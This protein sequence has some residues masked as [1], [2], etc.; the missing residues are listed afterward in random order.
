[1]TLK[2]CMVF[3]L[4]FLSA[5]SDN[6]GNSNKNKLAETER[7]NEW[8]DLRYEEELLQS[9]MTMTTLGQKKQYH[10]IDDFSEQTE[11]LLL[12][13]RAN[14]V[15]ELQNNFDYNNLSDDA[16]TSYDLWVY[17]YEQAASMAVYRRHQYVF[18]HMMGI[19][20]YLPNFMINFH[21]VDTA[22]DMN[23]YIS[24]IGGISRAIDQL[25]YR[26]QI[27]AK[28][29]VRP[30]KFSY[31]GV[32]DQSK[33]LIL[34]R[35]FDTKSSN[36]SPLLAD[37][38][39]KIKALLKAGKID[40]EQ[41]IILQSNTEKALLE[42]FYPAYTALIQWFVEDANNAD[43][44]ARGVSVLPQGDDFY[45]AS[46]QK[47]TTTMMTA[48]EIH[49][50]GLAEVKRLRSEMESIK[51]KVKFTGTLQQ[52]FAFIKA[53]PEF[54]Y[55]NTDVGRQEYIDDA[56][57]YLEKINNQLP[58][59]FGLLP[60][61]KLVVKRV[62]AFR[63]QDGAPQHYYPGTPDGS[64]AGIYYAHLSDMAAM[65]KN[66]MEAIAYHEGVPGHHMQISIQQELSGVPKFRTQLGFTSYAEGWA[67]YAE[68]LAKDMGAYQDPYTDFGRVVTEMWRAIRLVVDTGIH[69]KAWSEERAI[70]YFKENSPIP[71]AS[72]RS[73]VRRYIV[74]P[75]QATAY[76]I[77]MLKIMAIRQQAEL[78]LGDNFDIRAFHDTVLGGGAMPL[79][80]LERRVER[81]V[82]LS[83][84]SS[85]F[86]GLER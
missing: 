83:K 47:N 13:W 22:A 67:L 45:Q 26:A 70:A 64:R 61:A 32:I 14:T 63:E 73:E 17:E 31:L 40:K 16:K 8:F 53:S 76:K 57:A 3:L 7:L 78:V 75:G 42:R 66:E 35:P 4:S 24:R 6:G 79:S 34:G 48:E 1:M 38:K 86:N 43:K 60:K 71:D 81:W 37:A 12:Q 80:M 21:K 10:K 28:Q 50:V 51:D 29:D 27:G 46:L 19:H 69:A 44:I 56:K 74:W 33:K 68:S 62:E 36:D 85:Q 15:T 52:F 2:L 84:K 82:T 18:T 65:P 49:N 30:P 11:E 20:T 54:Y 9:P 23:A 41:S 59:Y 39:V 72:V 58:E 77:G 25:L 55:D 5:C